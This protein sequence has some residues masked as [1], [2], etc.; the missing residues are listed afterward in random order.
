VFFKIKHGAYLVPHNYGDT[1]TKFRSDIYIE[2]EDSQAFGTDLDFYWYRSRAAYMADVSNALINPL[3]TPRPKHYFIHAAIAADVSSACITTDF[4]SYQSSY[5]MVRANGTLFPNQTLRIFVLKHDPY[6][7]YTYPSPADYRQMPIDLNY[8]KTKKTPVTNY[9]TPY[10]TLFNSKKFRNTYDLSGVSNNLLDHFVITK[11]FSHY[12]P[13]DFTDNTTI[14]ESPLRFT[15]QFKTKAIGPPVGTSAWSQYYF[16][17]SSNAI[18]DTKAGKIYYDSTTA[19]EEIANGGLKGISNEFVFANWFSAGANNNLYK[20]A[21]SPLSIPE[22]TIATVPSDF[23]DPN[24]LFTVMAPIE[25]PP[26]TWLGDPIIDG[27]RSFKLSPFLICKNSVNINTDISFNDLNGHL[28]QNQIYLGQDIDPSGVNVKEIMA[29]PF[30]PPMGRYILPTRVVL[31]FAYIQPTFTTAGT[32]IGR[33][34]SLG[35]NI[36]TASRFQTQSTDIVYGSPAQDNLMW[37]DHYWQNRRN[38]VLGIYRTRDIMGVNVNT[39][40]PANALC[41][42]TLKKVVQ[43]GQYT[44]STD[45][46]I[47]NTRNRTPEWG[48][49]Y[50]YTMNTSAS[51]LWFSWGLETSEPDG[52]GPQGVPRWAAI[53][54]PADLSGNIFMKNYTASDN[55][56]SYYSDVSN[57][58]LCFIPFAPVLTDSEKGH[59]QDRNT[60]VAPFSKSISNNAAWEVGSFSGLTYTTRP[61]LPITRSQTLA[62]NPYIFYDPGAGPEAVCVEEIGNDGISMG[63]TSTY[64]GVAGPFC[65]GKEANGTVVSPN[66][67]K[68]GFR[69]TF[70]NV[71]INIRISDTLYNPLFDLTKF[72]G[73]N[74][75]LL[76]YVDTQTYFYDISKN[77]T[78]ALNDIN[79][80]WGAEKASRF[81]RYDDDSGFNYLSYMPTVNLTAN[82]LYQINVRGYVP[83]VK[84]L[85]GIRIVGK[86]WTDFGRIS[87]NNL[88]D[89]IAAVIDAGISIQSDG[90]LLNDA[91]RLKLYFTY[92][93][94]R[95][96]LLFNEQFT[97]SFVF[98]RGIINPS[99]PGVTVVSTGFGDFMRQFIAF[100]TNIKDLVN[101]ITSA[102]S[103][104]LTAVRKYIATNYSGI[105]PDVVLQRN[106]FTDPL[107]YSIQFKSALID[108]YTTA[109]DQWGLGW[110]L[111]F[112]KIDTIYNTRH[113]AI[114]FIRIVDDYIYLK[115]DDEL[116]I[117]NIDISYKEDL[118]QS[119]DTAGQSKR[120]YGKLLLNSFGSFAQTFIQSAKA[121]TIPIGRLDK[122]TFQLVDAYNR[123]LSNNDCE[124]NIVLG[125]DEMVDTVDTASIVVKGT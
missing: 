106:R 89:E 73:Y 76:C 58:S 114:T 36:R 11:D 24:S 104:A 31:K 59:S 115:L 37:D 35:T 119:R 75:A 102:S 77:P 48:T 85:S 14:A 120:Y 82:H 41:T 3:S 109:Y 117:N 28:N 69:P 10:N 121:F 113:V 100:N 87:F 38:V 2:R 98:G 111:G 122:L 49:Y 116:N 84:F 112:D 43:I 22:E 47:A 19:A 65:L 23:N 86:N 83:T 57:N 88:I 25:Y 72:G 12:D 1:D 13:Y 81:Q 52:A 66:Y 61:Y 96:L 101:G 107:T 42:L 79:T 51:N 105:L 108:P 80:A 20:T 21:L 91:K 123:Q 99:Y 70:F 110:N 45:P 40:S 16:N 29:I 95:T 26:G 125:I 17:G 90:R 27:T 124:Y 33:I 32:K 60:G 63:D 39:I 64:L 118:S 74:Q 53:A 44:G 6:G 54:K 78:S 5:C 103:A 8:L 93:Y 4:I 34:S 7:V 50:V 18:F 94:T 68:A 55:L 15:F 67:R 9:P 92:D 71:R 62:E 97:G 56:K 30:I 46:N